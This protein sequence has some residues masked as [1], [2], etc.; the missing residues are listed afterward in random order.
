MFGG[1]FVGPGAG[2]GVAVGA[3]FGGLEFEV[4]EDFEAC[5]SEEL[6]PFGDREIE[7]D[8]AGVYFDLGPVGFVE[9]EVGSVEFWFADI[10]AG[11]HADEGEGGVAEEGEVS[12]W[13]EDAVGFGDPS[14][15]VAPDG[16][17]VFA[18]GEVEMVIGVGGGFGVAVMEGEGDV[19]IFCESFRRFELFFGVVDSGC[20]CAAAGQPCGD[21]GGAAAEFEGG[22]SGEVLG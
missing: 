14:V 18:D 6:E 11:W 1:P 3:V 10:A 16:G 13:F 9:V 8:A 21:V 17:A 20:D 15:G 19:V 5:F 2:G 7:F 22:F 4:V 12:A